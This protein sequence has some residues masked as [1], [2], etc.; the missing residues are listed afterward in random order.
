VRAGRAS[1]TS[2]I[3]VSAVFDGQR[4]VPGRVALENGR[5]VATGVQ[6]AGRHFFASPGLIDLQT[7]GFAGVDFLAASVADLARAREAL[8]AHGVTAFQPTLI[9]APATATFRQLAGGSRILPA[10]LEG[11][12]LSPSWPGAHDPRY[13]SLP[14]HDLLERLLEAGPVGY[15]TVAPELPGG[16]ELVRHLRERGITVAIGHSDAT[17]DQANAAFD[18]GASAL[19]HAFNA[20]RPLM[21]REP[22]PAGAALV[23]EDVFIELITDGVHLADA[24]ISI[25]DHCARDRV[26]L[27]TDAIVAAGM[28]DGAF[29]FGTLDVTVTDGRATLSDGRLA[30]SVATLDACLRRLV[31]ASVPLE[32][33]LQAVTIRP[34]QLIGRDDLGQLVPGSRADL[35]VFD[36]ELVPVRTYLDGQIAWDASI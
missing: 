28:G 32:Q 6:P 34:A 11:P 36:E 27:V 21:A 18:A 14:D 3:D 5:V 7:N 35:V 4:I 33:A 23:R 17:L 15:M 19:T 26:I 22:G 9:S 25:V 2:L 12:F 31:A 16:I 20:H 24:V 1:E 30:G 8:L 13:L 29:K 10:H